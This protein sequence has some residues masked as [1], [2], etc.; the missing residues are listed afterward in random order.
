M[1][2]QR[3]DIAYENHSVFCNVQRDNLVENS[4]YVICCLQDEDASRNCTKAQRLPVTSEELERMLREYRERQGRLLEAQMAKNRHH[5]DAIAIRLRMAQQ[6]RVGLAH[7][8][9]FPASFILENR[10][11]RDRAKI[12]LIVGNISMQAVV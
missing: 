1:R 12:Y 10:I 8:Q 9:T 5:E 2:L 11:I 4:R 3:I 6:C 7:N